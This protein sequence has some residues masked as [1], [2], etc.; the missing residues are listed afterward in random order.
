MRVAGEK[1]PVP[2]RAGEG[3]VEGRRRRRLRRHRG[4]AVDPEPAGGELEEVADRPRLDEDVVERHRERDDGRE[5]AEIAAEA[6]APEEAH[7]ARPRM[8]SLLAA[9]A[10][11][12]PLGPSDRDA[13]EEEGAEVRDE[14]GTAAVLGRLARKAE[15]VSE[16]DRGARD[17]QDDAEAGAPL[18]SVS[19]HRS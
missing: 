12:R 11:H 17:G 7:D 3:G 13:E 6:P 19:V 16:A 2:G 8:E 5:D 18:L 4:R 14:E 15:E 9:V 10:A 1:D